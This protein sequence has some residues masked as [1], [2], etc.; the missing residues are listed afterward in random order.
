MPSAILQLIKIL[1]GFLILTMIL[2][3]C[4]RVTQ[5]LKFDK[6]VGLSNKDI[7]TISITNMGD[8]SRIILREYADIETVAGK[9]KEYGFIP[10]AKTG[11]T[12]T[13]FLVKIVAD[14][15]SQNKVAK[16]QIDGSFAEFA[17]ALYTVSKNGAASSLDTFFES[18]FD[19]R[20]NLDENNT[21][22]ALERLIGIELAQVKDITLTELKTGTQVKLR[23]PEEKN[24][25]LSFLHSTYLRQNR[26]K[27]VKDWADNQELSYNISLSINP[28]DLDMTIHV[29]FVGNMVCLGTNYWYDIVSHDYNVNFFKT[30]SH[31]F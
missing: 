19:Q 22:V 23:S 25:L 5:S 9:L 31:S 3:G 15:T 29:L 2:S 6:L 12:L 4:S 1:L 11:M 16:L 10:S 7:Q 26:S 13:G 8:G 17:G 30:L 18:Q 14:D 27:Q 24:K 20:W 21:D 28:D